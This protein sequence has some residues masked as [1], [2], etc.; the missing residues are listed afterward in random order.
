MTGLEQ[1]NLTSSSVVEK[2][3]HTLAFFIYTQQLAFAMFTI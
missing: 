1:V 2:P 3:S